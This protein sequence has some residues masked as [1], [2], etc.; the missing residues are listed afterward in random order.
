MQGSPQSPTHPDLLAGRD[1]EEGD[2]RKVLLKEGAV[3][4]ATQHLLV[5]GSDDHQRTVTPDHPKPHSE[6]G[7]KISTTAESNMQ[8]AEPID[9]INEAMAQRL[10]TCLEPTE[11]CTPEASWAVV[12]Q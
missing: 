11:R 9:H 10:Q 7:G 3:A 6:E 12:A 5:G 2:L 1:G 4:Y 8:T